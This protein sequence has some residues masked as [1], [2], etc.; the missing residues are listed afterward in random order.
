MVAGALMAYVGGRRWAEPRI[1]ALLPG[2]VV[3]LVSAGLTGGYGPA[4]DGDALVAPKLTAPVFSLAAILTVTPVMVVFI[5]L[6]AN[7]PSVVYLRVQGYRS[8]E[9]TSPRSVGTA[10]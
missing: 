6:Q 2:L 10:R 4:P 5:T 8:P 9:R 1:P 3:V 7:I